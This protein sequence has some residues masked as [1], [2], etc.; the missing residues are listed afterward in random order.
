MSW[1]TFGRKLRSR[2]EATKRR[3]KAPDLKSIP[4]SSLS[5]WERVRVRAYRGQ[6]YGWV[7]S[8]QAEGAENGGERELS[9]SLFI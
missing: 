9:K 6:R 8:Q 7:F 4:M 5:L 1:K 2:I 3:K